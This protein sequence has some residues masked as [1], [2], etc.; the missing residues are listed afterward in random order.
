MNPVLLG[1]VT[2]DPSDPSGFHLTEQC[3]MTVPGVKT[4]SCAYPDTWD[5]YVGSQRSLTCNLKTM[6]V[7]VL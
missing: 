3:F 6:H 2:P 4:A 7:K 1:I 5:Q